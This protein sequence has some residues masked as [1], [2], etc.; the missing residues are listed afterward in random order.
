VVELEAHAKDE[1]EGRYLDLFRGPNLR[2]SITVAVAFAC[3][4]FSGVQF[5]LGF[6][7]YFFQL[8]GFP[9]AE[10]FKLNVGTLS[11]AFVGNLIGLSLINRVGRRRLFL[12]GMFNCGCACF[13]LA[14]CSVIP[15]QKALWGQASFTMLYMLAFQSGIGPVAYALCGELGSAKLRAKTVGWGMTVHNLSV[16]TTQVILPYLVNPNEANLKGKVGWIFFGSCVIGGTWAYFFVPET[17]HRNVDE[18]DELFAR[19]I[20]ARKFHTTDLGM[21]RSAVY[22][23]KA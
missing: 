15:G 8:A 5:V 23:V 6:S 19:G 4:E 21:D 3:Q 11:L 17:A 16:G 18:L 10:S 20:S 22:T 13:G 7:T 2:R 9:T 14:I 1:V 12:I